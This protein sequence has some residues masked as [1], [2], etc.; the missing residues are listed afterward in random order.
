[1]LAKPGIGLPEV[2]ATV[3]KDPAII[4]KLIRLANSGLY[5]RGVTCSNI[6]EAVS[7]L[8][9]RDCCEL[10]MGIG[11]FARFEHLDKLGRLI[12]SESAYWPA[13]SRVVRA[14]PPSGRP[15]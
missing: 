9:A 14:A 3:E 5:F 2:I 15:S 10:L 8:G 1:M 4:A 7:R 13:P 6:A 12:A 11:L